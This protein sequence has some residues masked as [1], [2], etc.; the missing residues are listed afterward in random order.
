MSC[1][2]NSC[3][4]K[5][6]E[7]RWLKTTQISSLA[8]LEVR[9]LKRVSLPWPRD[10]HRAVLL[11]KVLEENRFPCLSGFHS[12]ALA[13][14][15]PAEQHLQISLPHLS[16]SSLSVATFTASLLSFIKP[17]GQSRT[18]SRLKTLHCITSAGYHAR[19]PGTRTGRLW[20]PP[21]RPHS[22][23][24][25]LGDTYHSKLL[26]DHLHKRMCAF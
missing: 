8:L 20:G 9:N 7:T 14:S 2:T 15:R 10:L 6:P 12:C 4:N 19:V 22:S 18:N 16:F 13:S 23:G 11:L 17:H 25:L 3:C 26:P 5:R 24:C 21:F 1:R